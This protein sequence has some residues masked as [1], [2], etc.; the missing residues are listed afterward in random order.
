[1][2]LF[3]VKNEGLSW[4]SDADAAVSRAPFFAR[5]GIR[6]KVEEY[7][8]TQ[9]KKKITVE[10]VNNVK[11]SFTMEMHRDIKGYQVSSCFSSSGCPNRIHD[12]GKLLIQLE[13]ELKEA[14]IAG[15]L[16]SGLKGNLRYHHEFRLTLSD[17]PN[18][19]SQPQ[20]ADFA[21]V[22]ASLP[23]VVGKNCT[24]CGECVNAC[25][26][27]AIVLD[28][29]KS[30]PL[31]NYEKCQKCG[32]CSKTCRFNEIISQINGYRI[33]SGGRLGR[34]PRLGME[35]SGVFNELEVLKILKWCLGFYFR[36]SSGG[37]R[38][39]HVFSDSDFEE[40]AR[41]VDLGCFSS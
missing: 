35:L 34:H 13:K 23:L 30:L 32:I 27:R 29:E 18:S 14:D 20:I 19:C 33:L 21:L 3:T 15:F 6:A 37:K 2:K 12:S 17:C 9:G 11:N 40:L 8:R 28:H 4:D 41:S 36:K 7:C 24:L 1:M 16:K 31:I 38:F 10:D 22:A 26:D 39:S 5:S 25:P